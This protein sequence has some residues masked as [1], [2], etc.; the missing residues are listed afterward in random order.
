MAHTRHTHTT[1]RTSHIIRSQCDT[2]SASPIRVQRSHT[3]TIQRWNANIITRTTATNNPSTPRHT[4]FRVPNMEQPIVCTDDVAAV[5]PNHVPNLEARPCTP[6]LPQPTRGACRVRGYTAHSSYAAVSGG[7]MSPS[8]VP[9]GRMHTSPHSAPPA[10]TLSRRRA[11]QSVSRGNRKAACLPITP[12]SVA[13]AQGAPSKR[14]DHSSFLIAG[15]AS[16]PVV[17]S[18]SVEKAVRVIV[19]PCALAA[20]RGRAYREYLKLDVFAI[21]RS[22]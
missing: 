19:L 14:H 8:P 22:W 4:E 20:G 3:Y 17:P 5:V 2:V 13:V 21:V 18:Q 1:H 15:G 12:W 16:P 6:P 10:L 9:S 11:T 7:T